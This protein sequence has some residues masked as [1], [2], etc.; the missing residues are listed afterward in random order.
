MK[1]RESTTGTPPRGSSHHDA[2]S[3]TGKKSYSRIIVHPFWAP[4]KVFALPIV[5]RLYRNRQGLTKGKKNKTKANKAKPDPHHRT[6][7]QL[8]VELISLVAAWFPH[9]DILVTGDSAYGGQSILFG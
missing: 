8:A 9:D 2:A 3:R 4:T 5:M 7:P 6:R 1:R